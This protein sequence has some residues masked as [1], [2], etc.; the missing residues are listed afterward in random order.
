VIA[1]TLAEFY[2][3][4]R[5]DYVTGPSGLVLSETVARAR[6]APREPVCIDLFEVRLQFSRAGTSCDVE[7]PHRGL[8]KNIRVERWAGRRARASQSHDPAE[9]IHHA[10]WPLRLLS[11]RCSS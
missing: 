9:R 7:D 11:R 8:R 3:D 1:A 4:L 5:C 6:Y 2:S 10:S